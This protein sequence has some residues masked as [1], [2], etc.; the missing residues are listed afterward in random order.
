MFFRMILLSAF[1][2]CICVALERAA[3]AA[4]RPNLLVILV[5]DLGYGDLSSYVAK[6]LQ[7]PQI[8]Q[9]VARAE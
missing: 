6:D 9:L 7:T 2:L 4:D 3:F 8:D 1:T 5:D